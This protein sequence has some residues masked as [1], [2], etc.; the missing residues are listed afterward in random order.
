[1]KSVFILFIIMLTIASAS[2]QDKIKL[3]KADKKIFAYVNALS[4]SPLYFQSYITRGTES[5]GHKP[6]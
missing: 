1:M 2:A 3:E 5:G 6:L 4:E